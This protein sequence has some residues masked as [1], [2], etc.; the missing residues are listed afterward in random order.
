MKHHNFYPS[1]PENASEQD[2]LDAWNAL[3]AVPPGFYRLDDATMIEIQALHE[4]ISDDEP[5]N[6]VRDIKVSALIGDEIIDENL[7][8][9]KTTGHRAT[10]LYLPPHRSDTSWQS[11]LDRLHN[12][13]AYLARQEQL[14]Q[15]ARNLRVFGLPASNDRKHTV[16]R[17]A[18][19][20]ATALDEDSTDLYGDDG[21]LGAQDR[22]TLVEHS[23]KVEADAI[24]ERTARRIIETDFLT[25]DTPVDSETIPKTDLQRLV[26]LAQRAA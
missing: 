14:A 7:S 9:H 18:T 12:N 2:L 25:T 19:A 10:V 22:A 23:L 11:L 5:K 3:D 24:I 21:R 13:P 6:D 4:S 8:I 1:D 16:T 15:I 26:A 17:V 20:I